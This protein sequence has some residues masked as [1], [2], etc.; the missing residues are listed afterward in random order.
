MQLA[1][2]ICYMPN[3]KG[4][5]PE[6]LD[7]PLPNDTTKL[8]LRS[9]WSRFIRSDGC[10]VTLNWTKVGFR[11]RAMV[12]NFHNKKRKGWTMLKDENGIVD[13]KKHSYAI[14]RV[15]QYIS[16]NNIL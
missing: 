8:W 10:E 5:L 7:L 6:M 14:K 13:F 3:K 9:S 16:D 2:E 15:E 4:K 12:P 11:W 1:W